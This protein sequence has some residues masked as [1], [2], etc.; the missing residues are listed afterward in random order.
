M[1]ITL[2]PGLVVTAPVWA[3]AMTATQVRVFTV[4]GRERVRVEGDEL[5]GWKIEERIRGNDRILNTWYVTD[6][7]PFMLL[8]ES[9]L[10][11]GRRQR[12]TGVALDAPPESR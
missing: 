7:S 1:A 9:E 4:L 3:P 12:I 11:D 5:E 6:V 10:P 2:R 8:A